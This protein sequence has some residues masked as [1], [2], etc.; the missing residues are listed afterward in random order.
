M[1]LQ[2]S[3]AKWQ[4]SFALLQDSPAKLQ[5]FLRYYKIAYLRCSFFFALLQDSLDKLPGFFFA[6]LQDSFA[7]LQSF[8]VLLQDSLPKLQ[9]L[10]HCCSI[11]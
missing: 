5:F 9:F 11:A 1:L 2:D 3:L 6:V 8:F 10:L 7:K 4:V